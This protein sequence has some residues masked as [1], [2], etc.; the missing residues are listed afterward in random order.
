M[1][2]VIGFSEDSIAIALFA[3]DAIDM[4]AGVGDNLWAD[5]AGATRRA[6]DQARSKTTKPPR[7]CLVM[8]TIVGREADAVLAGLRDALGPGVPIVGGGA[9]PEDPAKPID[10]E[11]AH[12]IA[13]DVVAEDAVAIL[14]FS[15]DLDYSFGVETGWLGVGPRGVVTRTTD[16]GSVAEID[17]RPAVDFYARYLGSGPPPIANPLAVFESLPNGRFYLRTPVSY[18]RETGVVRFFGPVPIGATVQITVAA[19]DQIFEGTKA[20]VVEA[21]AAF[22]G[23]RTPDAALI[24][25]CATRRYMLGTRVGREVELVREILGNDIPIAGMYCLGEIAPMTDADVSRFH[26]ATLV[27][28]LLGAS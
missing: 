2:S 22:P 24:Y 20:S 21:L 16:D 4:T 5:P 28:V 17:G 10:E 14:L 7:L 3:S 26:N 19:I 9:S 18:D 13:G 1:S 11:A 25:S 8:P 23:G 12:Q 27:S 15:G 6:V